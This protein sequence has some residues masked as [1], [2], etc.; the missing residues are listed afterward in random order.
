MSLGAP[1]D[2]TSD[3]LALIPQPDP[4]EELQAAEDAQAQ[5]GQAP[6]Q[7]EQPATE[8]Q[9]DEPAAS[10][11]TTAQ[12]EQGQQQPEESAARRAL[13]AARRSEDRARREADQLRAEVEALRA[14]VPTE[15]ADTGDLSDDEIA[16]IAQDVPV[17]AK[18]AR[19]LKA[20]EQ[21]IP[22]A[23][24]QRQ[25][26]DF[27]PPRLPANVQEVV[28]VVPELFDWQHNPDQ[29]LFR[30][31]IG[32]DTYLQQQPAWANK[33]MTERF[34][35]VVRRV[36]ADTG[37]SLPNP[38]RIDPAQAI[39]QAKPAMPNTLSDVRGGGVAQPEQ[40]MRDRFVSARSDD[41]IMAMLD[42]TG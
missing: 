7:S 40:S 13:R 39:R 34:A 24:A 21:Q 4:A 19:R 28:D 26:P 25:E 17:V 38:T 35:E 9:Q 18:L 14:K 36:K 20:L 22:A 23:Q 15:Q 16:A 29:A 8:Q 30:A 1:E 2:F 37:A 27:E 31:A 12:P 10:Q 33:P 41:E 11:Q 6:Q 5:Q 42:R 32:M 3:E